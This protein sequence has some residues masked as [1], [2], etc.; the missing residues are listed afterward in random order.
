MTRGLPKPVRR[1]S[2][3]SAVAHVLGVG[4]LAPHRAAPGEITPTAIEGV[5]LRVLVAEDNQVNQLLVT[6]ILAK[7]GMRAEVAAKRRRRAVQAVHQRHFR[8]HPEWICRCRR[9]TASRRR[10]ASGSWVRSAAPYRS[11]P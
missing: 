2:L 10:G 3:I 6:T 9:W 8:R 7:A 4:E 11:S 5:P 1:S